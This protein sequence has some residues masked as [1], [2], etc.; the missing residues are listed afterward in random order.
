MEGHL[1]CVKAIM[2]AGQNTHLV[3][4]DDRSALFYAA[5]HNR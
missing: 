4:R 5:K 1:E 3:D 2:E